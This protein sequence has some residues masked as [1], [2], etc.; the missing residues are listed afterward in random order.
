MRKVGLSG[1]PER[2]RNQLIDMY[3]EKCLAEM[4][5]DWCREALRM[6]KS[7]EFIPRGRFLKKIKN[8]Q[9]PS[10]VIHGMKDALVLL[11]QAHYLVENLKNSR[12]IKLAQSI[13]NM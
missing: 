10:L 9:C 5:D 7:D 11:T 3:G 6:A 4:W 2:R 12:Y 1:I 13:K 8:V